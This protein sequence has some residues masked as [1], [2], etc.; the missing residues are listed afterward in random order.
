[1]ACKKSHKDD[2]MWSALSNIEITTLCT[3]IVETEFHKEMQSITSS[4]Q[5]QRKYCPPTTHMCRDIDTGVM[6]KFTSR[7]S[8]W[9]I[10]YVKNPPLDT[11]KFHSKF[12]KRFRMSY[13]SYLK[14]L[15]KI[16]LHELFSPWDTL[17]TIWRGSA[18]AQIE[19]LV[20]GCLRYLGRGWAFDDLEEATGIS[21]ETH[22]KFLHLFLIWGSSCFSMKP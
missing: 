7:D 22:R 18:P 16:K 9:Y 11:K 12:R 2:I 6:R 21:A 3:A 1:M 8:F 5:R 13:D 4:P 14:I 19:L 15:Q 20:L 10:Y 17:K